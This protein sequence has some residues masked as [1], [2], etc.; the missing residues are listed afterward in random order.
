LLGAGAAALITSLACWPRL[1]AW[2]GRRDPLVFLW[3]LL[4]WSAFVLW[5]FVLGWHFQYTGKRPL[6]LRGPPRLWL[7]ATLYGLASALALRFFID[8]RMRLIAPAEYPGDW[9]SWFA[10]G[11]FTLAFEPLFLWFAPFAFFVR[12]ARSP[13]T[14]L[15]LT[16]LF[17]VFVLYLRLDSAPGLPPPAF[18]AALVLLRVVGGFVGLY[19]YLN[20]GAWPAWW[21]VLLAHL[22]HLPELLRPH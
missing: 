14:A 13:P 4:L 6:A 17:G 12:L 8:P 21:L 1:A 9:R 20:G 5:S 11:G 18:L 3:L 16:V 10:L 2:P 19:F 7:T 15:A 22:R